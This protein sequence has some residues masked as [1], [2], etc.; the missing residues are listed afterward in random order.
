MSDELCT[1]WQVYGDSD[2]E[3][4]APTN[5]RIATSNRSDPDILPGQ[6]TAAD[7]SSDQWWVKPL[8]MAVSSERTSRGAQ[9]RP[10]RIASGCSGTEAP[11]FGL[12]A[13]ALS[14]VNA[15][16]INHVFHVSLR[17]PCVCNM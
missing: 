3:L 12:K 4:T 17:F 6:I 10:L 16:L 8:M 1:Q 15:L 14:I 5:P 9:L 7:Y 2:D 11:S 13:C